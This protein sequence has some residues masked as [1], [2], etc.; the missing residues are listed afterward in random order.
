MQ[1]NE[2]A[3]A[4]THIATRT[5]CSIKCRKCD[6]NLNNDFDGK[7]DSRD[8]ECSYITSSTSAFPIPGQAEPVTDEET[9]RKDEEDEQESDEDLNEEP[10]GNENSDGEGDKKDNGSNDDDEDED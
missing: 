3:T 9:E 4:A 5:S 6:D 2:A 7:V 1:C 8:E 10:G